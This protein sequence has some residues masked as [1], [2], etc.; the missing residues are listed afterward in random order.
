MPMRNVWHNMLWDWWQYSQAEPVP[1]ADHLSQH[2]ESR[3]D[4][5]KRRIKPLNE[6]VPAVRL[7]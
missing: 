6:G 5:L 7:T 4:L 2:I 1:D 3:H